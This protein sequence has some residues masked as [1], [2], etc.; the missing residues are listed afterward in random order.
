[1]AKVPPYLGHP[2]SNKKLVQR[3]QSRFLVWSYDR[4]Q[5]VDSHIRVIGESVYKE[6][7]SRGMKVQAIIEN[8]NPNGNSYVLLANF[9]QFAVLI[10]KYNPLE[11]PFTLKLCTHE[12]WHS[13]CWNYHCV[14]LLPKWLVFFANSFTLGAEWIYTIEG[15][16][17]GVSVLQYCKIDGSAGYLSICCCIPLPCSGSGGRLKLLQ[18]AWGHAFR[19]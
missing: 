13:L 7:Y 14:L 15:P 1:M 8:R 6:W 5:V 9:M 19:K 12:M 11:W 4:R 10:A 18:R 2:P 16:P 3:V 17:T